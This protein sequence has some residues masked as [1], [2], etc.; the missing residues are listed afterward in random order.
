[1]GGQLLTFDFE[2]QV[3][4]RGRRWAEGV[5]A[6]RK[7]GAEGHRAISERRPGRAHLFSHL[8]AAAWLLRT[9]SAEQSAPGKA[10]LRSWYRR[11]LSLSGSGPA[12][13]ALDLVKWQA[14]QSVCKPSIS[15]HSPPNCT[16]TIWSTSNRPALPHLTQRQPSRSSTARRTTAHRRGLVVAGCLSRPK[17]SA[18]ALGLGPGPL[19]YTGAQTLRR[20]QRHRGPCCLTLFW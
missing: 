5:S 16:G 19:E 2:Y 15:H 1:M 13:S 6:A 4:P 7:D 10:L 11:H 12:R 3:T 14:R 17:V 9:A 8:P 18:R 20:Q